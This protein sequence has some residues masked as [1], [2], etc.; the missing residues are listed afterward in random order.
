MVDGDVTEGS[1]WMGW[2]SYVVS[3][4]EIR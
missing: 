1:V 4:A 2:A 3:D